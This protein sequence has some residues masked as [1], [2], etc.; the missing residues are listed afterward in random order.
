MKISTIGLSI[1]ALSGTVH[2]RRVKEGF[3]VIQGEKSEDVYYG[4]GFMHGLDRILQMSITR[5]MAQGRVSE[6]LSSTDETIAMDR[7]FRWIKL[8]RDLDREEKRLK[9]ETKD[10]LQAYCDGVNAAVN[11]NGVPLEMKLS[12]YKHEPWNVTD[13]L[14]LARTVAYTGLT[15]SQGEGEK[16]II[17]L[18]Q[19]DIDDKMI[20]ELF[21]AIKGKI[22]K[23]LREHL[24]ALQTWQPLAGPDR[25]WKY[26]AA[27]FSASNNWAVRKGMSAGDKP[28]LCNDPHM[29]LMLPSLWYP[30]LMKTEKGYLSGVTMAGAPLVLAGRNSRLAWG[31]TYGCADVMDYFIEDI[32]EGKFRRDKKWERCTVRT[33][34]LKPKRKP[35]Q[36]W[37]VH[38]TDHG[39]IEGEVTTGGYYL[40]LA[41]SGFEKGATA[42]TMN[43][44]LKLHGSKDV[45]E[46]MKI[47]SR[48]Q[49]AAFNWVLADTRGDIGYQMSGNIPKRE[50]SGLLPYYGWDKNSKWKKMIKTDKLP[51]VHNPRGDLIVTA[52]QD[53]NRLGKVKAMTLPMSSW[54]ANRISEL[55]KKNKKNGPREMAS[56]Q[57]DD[58]SLQAGAYM[59]ILH[60]ILPESEEAD[61]LLNWDTRYSPGSRGAALFEE[62]YRE[63]VLIVFG[64]K[65]LGRDV[66]EHVM[67]KTSV[68]A[69]YHGHFDAVLLS[70]E[71]KW[72]RGSRQEDLFLEALNRVLATK[73]R[74]LK[75]RQRTVLRNPILPGIP[76]RLTGFSASIPLYGSRATVPQRQE[77][78]FQGKTTVFGPSM[79]MIATLDDDR[80]MVALPGGPSERNFTP[81]YRSALKGFR[82]GEFAVLDPE[83]S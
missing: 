61:P 7:H 76:G 4:L 72:F 73:N 60:P 8:P 79:R 44:F 47:C 9:S 74:P 19:N 71:S 30:V 69:M 31:V 83:T 35:I 42:E 41:W 20:L 1:E 56:I 53:L 6:E 77:I 27:G 78:H 24:K 54:R 57:T 38:E 67:D 39:T 52:N 34:I 51:A 37:S 64:E 55:L 62:F 43:S 70:S 12:G 68:F 65:N 66:M 32:R 28:I 14:L 15:Q 75:S 36:S 13:V 2:L 29:A 18:L 45:K 59:K 46:G 49:L 48:L 50:G 3:P 11:E 58:L 25:S 22:P 26:R 23:G 80:L 81:W 40:S 10:I 33:E 82:R 17:E 63:L 16:F 21:P 5:L